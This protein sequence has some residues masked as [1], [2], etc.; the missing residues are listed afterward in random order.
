MAPGQ[1]RLFRNSDQSQTYVVFWHRVGD[2]FF[3][4]GR[5]T[6]EML[7]PVTFW[8]EAARFM[9]GSNSEQYFFQISANVP[10]ETLW[11]DPGFRQVIRRLAGL[12]LVDGASR[13]VTP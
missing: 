1:W 2:R 12:G 7:D 6:A 9:I 10:P 5:K 8:T 4:Y 11:E 13:R 3:D